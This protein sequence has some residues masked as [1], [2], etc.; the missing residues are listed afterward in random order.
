MM[1]STYRDVFVCCFWIEIHQSD[2]LY[3]HENDKKGAIKKKDLSHCMNVMWVYMPKYAEK[4]SVKPSVEIFDERYYVNLPHNTDN[5]EI[6][7]WY[8]WLL[9]ES[10]PYPYPHRTCCIHVY[11]KFSLS[12]FAKTLIAFSHS[13]SERVYILN[14]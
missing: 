8:C 13:I 2:S 10:H 12:I 7:M 6:T 4:F 9:D 3:R 14:I 5:I 11:I 1:T